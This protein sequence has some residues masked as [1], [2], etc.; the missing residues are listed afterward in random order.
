M[1][2]EDV[3]I[4]SLAWSPDG[5]LMA[6]IHKPVGEETEIRIMDI[7]NKCL[8]NTLRIGGIGGLEWSPKGDV[9]AFMYWGDGALYFADVEEVFGAP[10]NEL[11][12]LP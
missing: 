6:Y 11:K 9:L 8:V 3:P 2:I 5:R 7:H 1:L 10:Y 12:C 4:T